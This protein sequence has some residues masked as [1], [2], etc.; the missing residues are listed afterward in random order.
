MSF[1]SPAR[2]SKCFLDERV[3]RRPDHA[4]VVIRHDLD[5]HVLQ[6][7]FH[8]P[9]VQEG[10]QEHGIIHLAYDLCRNAAPDENAPRGHEIQRAVSSLR[11]EHTDEN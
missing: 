8:A 2:C 3:T 7:G 10:F 11:A 6:D 1:R 4:G 5:R 9:F